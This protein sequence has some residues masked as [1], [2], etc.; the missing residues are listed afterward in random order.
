M[1][2]SA[3]L[4][5]DKSTLSYQVELLKDRLEEMQEAHTQLQVGTAPRSRQAEITAV[6]AVTPHH[7][8]IQHRRR[9]VFVSVRQPCFWLRVV[10]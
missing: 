4:D 7:I 8:D 1:V 10:G 9:E 6:S 3:Q 2:T 5:N